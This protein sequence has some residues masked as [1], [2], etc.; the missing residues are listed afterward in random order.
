AR[1]GR[2]AALRRAR[3]RGPA[4]L[5]RAGP[6]R[7]PGGHDHRRG[8]P[9][10]GTIVTM[11]Q[12]DARAKALALYDARRTR[13]PIAPFTDA[14]PGLGMAEGYAVQ[15]EL[16]ALLLADGDRIVGY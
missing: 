12:T 6:G 4:A 15:R 16:T 2:R 9:A 14:E 3:P 13:V 11:D 7:R 5:R 8:H 1:R 10:G